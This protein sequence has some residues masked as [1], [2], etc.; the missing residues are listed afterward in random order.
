MA[1]AWCTAP[2][3]QRV[4]GAPSQLRAH[5]CPR[6]AHGCAKPCTA[7]SC[8]SALCAG[9]EGTPRGHGG[10]GGAR[11]APVRLRCPRGGSRATGMGPAARCGRD[12]G[13]R[14]GRVRCAPSLPAAAGRAGRGS[15][16]P[17]GI[18]PHRT[19][20]PLDRAVRPG[21]PSGNPDVL[22]TAFAQTALKNANASLLGCLSQWPQKGPCWH[23]SHL[24]QR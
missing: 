2:H 4:P 14:T 8:A 9:S 13:T 1:H 11:G 10:G 19:A 17:A 22:K 16:V 3:M 7:R 15:G 24:R 18:I 6:D 20:H 23:L 5:A 21:I 12:T